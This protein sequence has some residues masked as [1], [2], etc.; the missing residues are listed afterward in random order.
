MPR[1]GAAGC[2]L[3]NF[4]E[5]LWLYS[6][7]QLHLLSHFCE[8]MNDLFFTSDVLPS[9]SRL[10]ISTLLPANS[11]HPFINLCIQQILAQEPDEADFDSVHFLPCR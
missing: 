10:S 6:S 2:P 7:M 1:K 4:T 8:R 11:Y 5:R 3:L 9:F